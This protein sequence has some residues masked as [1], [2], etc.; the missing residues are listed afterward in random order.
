[1]NH[2]IVSE[3]VL[4]QVLDAMENHDGNYKLSKACGAKF[5]EAQDKLRSIL[6][7]GPVEPDIFHHDCDCGCP[8]DCYG[9]ST[10]RYQL[11]KYL[12]AIP[13]EEA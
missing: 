2:Y 12:G 9:P 3:E 11:R 13:K 5:Q 4:R 6:S 8:C 10:A 1:M 7:K